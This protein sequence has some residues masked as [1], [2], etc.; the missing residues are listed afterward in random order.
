MEI[1]ICIVLMV[2]ATL[3]GLG[4]TLLT[5]PG[6]WLMLLVAGGIQWYSYSATGAGYFPL[7]LILTALG[8][9]LLGELLEFAASAVGAKTAGGSRASAIGA[10]IGAIV[11][12]LV[13]TAFV[14]PVGTVIGS[15]IGAGAGAL[16]LEI[17]WAK[18]ASWRS[19]GKIALGAAAGR[20]VATVIKVTIAIVVG[21]SLVIALLVRAAA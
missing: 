7:W 17:G 12:A 11:G 20:A 4:L 19:A 1:A 2:G 5:G 21:V 16:A 3:G 8:L 6:V 14:P 9:A 13:G 15:I 10:I 18:N